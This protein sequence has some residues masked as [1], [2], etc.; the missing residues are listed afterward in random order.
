[1]RLSAAGSVLVATIAI[2]LM[3]FAPNG[4]K[5]ADGGSG[6]WPWPLLGEVITP[7]KNGSD[8]YAAGQHRGLD[9]AAPAGTQVRAIVDGR[10][11]FAGTLP[12]G[13]VTVTVRSADGAYLA[14]GLHLASRVVTRGESVSL[15]QTLGTVGTTG[16]RSVAQPHLH[17]SVRRASDRAYVDPMALLGPRQLPKSAPVTAQLPAAAQTVAPAKQPR[18]PR[19]HVMPLEGRSLSNSKVH[20]HALGDSSPAQMHGAGSRRATADSSAGAPAREGHAARHVSR[21]APPPLKQPEVSTPALATASP[22]A[23]VA[24]K[25]AQTA[26]QSSGDG[27]NRYLLIAVAAVCLIAL[28]MRRRPRSLPG[29]NDSSPTAVAAGS[30]E[31]PSA[32]VIQLHR[33]S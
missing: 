4:A 29:Q 10:V 11:T 30:G 27:S 31:Q 6:A 14:S 8:R 9:I 18:V 19:A 25:P 3:L 22:P 13:G 32:E 15:G 17:L 1:L 21:V 23:P 5:A 7:Y 20:A 33:A 28:A 2:L 24:Q 16:K 26:S 12:D